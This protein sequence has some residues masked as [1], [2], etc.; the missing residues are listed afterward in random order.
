MLS[1]ATSV[2]AN[3]I[4]TLPPNGT[5]FTGMTESIFSLNGMKESSRISPASVADC[6]WNKYQYALEVPM[7]VNYVEYINVGDSQTPVNCTR[8]NLSEWNIR[9]SWF[10][11]CSESISPSAPNP[12]Q[13]S[14]LSKPNILPWVREF[15]EDVARYKNT[16]CLNGRLSLN[17]NIIIDADKSCITTLWSGEDTYTV[18]N[19]SYESVS[20]HTIPSLLRHV[21]PTNAEIEAA[22][23]T[24]VTPSLP[25]DMVRYV[26]FLKYSTYQLSEFF[27]CTMRWYCNFS[28]L[29]K[30]KIKIWLG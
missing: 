30:G 10:F 1:L 9:G 13:Y 3:D 29:V 18:D 21:S 5:A 17:G 25:I 7:K 27:Y 14:C 28:E 19:T 12:L 8:S 20:Y 2:P 22:K 16:N 23:N 11:G 24:N 4:F 15:S 26:E 6:I